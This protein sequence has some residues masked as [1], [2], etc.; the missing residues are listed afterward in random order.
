M[1]TIG[2]TIPADTMEKNPNKAEALP[3]RCPYSAIAI[4]KL[5]APNK[6]TVPTVKNRMVVTT[7]NGISKA[8]APK[9]RA[10]PKKRIYKL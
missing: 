5:A 7:R 10:E 1:P 4:E 8:M 9:N 3:A 2:D 6:D